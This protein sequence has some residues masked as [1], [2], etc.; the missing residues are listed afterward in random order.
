MQGLPLWDTSHLTFLDRHDRHA[1]GALFLTLAW[2]LGLRSATPGASTPPAVV[3]S[4]DMLVS[5]FC[6]FV[7]D[8]RG[9]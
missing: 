7:F 2:D 3:T 5:Q 6:S 4:V 1:F 9:S 8:F